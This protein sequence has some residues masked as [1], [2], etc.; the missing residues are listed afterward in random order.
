MS[1]CNIQC[2]SVISVTAKIPV[3]TVYDAYQAGIGIIF[4][5]KL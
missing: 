5:L 2:K 1:G 4:H 3:Q